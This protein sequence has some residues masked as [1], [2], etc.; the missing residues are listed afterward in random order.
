MSEKN[1]H[2]ILRISESGIHFNVDDKII[3]ENT[4]FPNKGTFSVRP[5]GEIFWQVAMIGFNKATGVLKVQVSDYN[6]GHSESFAQQNPKFKINRI[7][8]Q[9]L[10]WNKLQKVLTYYEI[11]KFEECDDG[12]LSQSNEAYENI[13]DARH[14]EFNQSISKVT[15]KM[16]YVETS[17][18]IKGVSNKV[19]IKIYNPEIIPEFE[20][21]KF[22]FSK[23]FG[24]RQIKIKGSIG[25]K[26]DR[27]TYKFS[28]PQISQ[29]NEQLINSIKRLEIKN[30]I[31]KPKVIAIDKSLFTPDEYF[32]GFEGEVGNNIRKS[33]QDLLKEI[34]ALESI[35]NRKQLEYISGYL[36]SENERIHFTLTPQFGFLFYVEGEDMHHFIWELLNSH[37]TYLWSKDKS[38]NRANFLSLVSRK[39]NYIRDQGRLQYINHE[40]NEEL[41]FSK[42]NHKSAGS[43]IVDGFPMWRKKL[44][45]KLV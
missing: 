4:N 8:F 31:K 2:I 41:I 27:S 32:D 35:R 5:S 43:N 23:I 44:N 18:S 20:Y 12:F 36:Q 40:Q 3:W 29:I 37:A 39:I 7:D 17:K 26:N 33:D 21:I 14:F 34:L 25:N 1:K 22:Y 6:N 11:N 15:F 30:K 9:D 13:K 38:H 45:E 24:S 28:S 42:I 19:L 10:H 16:G